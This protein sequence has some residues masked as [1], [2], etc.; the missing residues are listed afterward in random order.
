MMGAT[1]VQE[2]CGGT[3]GPYNKATNPE[4]M[5]NDVCME[6]NVH[7]DRHGVWLPWPRALPHAQVAC[8]DPLPRAP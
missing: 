7:T 5:Q 8:Q 2:T 3:E 6:I 4:L 1:E